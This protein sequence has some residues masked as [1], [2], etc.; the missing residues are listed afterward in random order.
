MAYAS[1]FVV[2]N[3]ISFLKKE[4]IP[5]L[6]SFAVTLLQIYRHNN[7]V[8]FVLKTTFFILN[9]TYYSMNFFV[10]FKKGVDF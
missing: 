7:G 9:L 10:S 4:R 6:F 5:L 2:F 8:F 1:L 3:V